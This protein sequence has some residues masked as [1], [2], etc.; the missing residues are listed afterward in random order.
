MSA[1]ETDDAVKS[2]LPAILSIRTGGLIPRVVK[3]WMEPR[4][5]LVEDP[6]EVDRNV[7]AVLR[8]ENE[9]KVYHEFQRAADMTAATVDSDGVLARL[10][11]PGHPL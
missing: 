10:T 4:W 5:L 11:S 7:A 1:L 6:F 2:D 9:I 3:G 8:S